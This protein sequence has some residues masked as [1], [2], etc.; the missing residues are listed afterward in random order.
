MVSL[1]DSTCKSKSIKIAQAF[2]STPL[3]STKM[4]YVLKNNKVHSY[5]QAL[6]SDTPNRA[7]TSE[8]LKDIRNSKL[9]KFV[10]N[11][12]TRGNTDLILET[13]IEDFIQ[14]YGD[15]L[16]SSYVI[17]SI[18]FTIIDLATNTVID[19]KTFKAK[20]TTTSQ[21]AMGGAK[22]L[23]KA[24]SLVLSQNRTWISEICK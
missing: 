16:S 19:A 12:K 9:F 14:Y 15:D 18:N 7:I 24:L 23:N 10:L 5:S 8:I 21:N 22:A 4:G 17:V 1:V 13:N 2:S 11:S 6:F 3:M 20:V